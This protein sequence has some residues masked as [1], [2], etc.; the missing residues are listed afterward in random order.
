MYCPQCGQTQ[1]GEVRYCSRCGL[2]L[3]EIG[4]WLG[5]NGELTVAEDCTMQ[6]SRRRRHILRAAK[7][8]FFSGFL[9]PIGF[10]IGQAQ[11][12]PQWLAIPLLVFVSSLIWMLYCRIFME[13]NRPTGNRR[14]LPT[15][16]ENYLPPARASL[17]L[18]AHR[19]NT[20]EIAQPPSV[21]E[22]TTNL[23]RNREGN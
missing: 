9:C 13:G 4:R 1:T 6:L 23:L 3:Y 19:I 8:A 2:S 15:A 5:G 10:V 21:T 20:A 16:Q 22:Y 11:R 18:D 7:V 14:Q 17:A 12:E